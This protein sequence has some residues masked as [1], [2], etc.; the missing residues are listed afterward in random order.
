MVCSKVCSKYAEDKL[1]HTCC[2]SF[3]E[4]PDYIVPSH[5]IVTHEKVPHRKRKTHH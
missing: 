4:M 3:A 5:K 2:I 1:L